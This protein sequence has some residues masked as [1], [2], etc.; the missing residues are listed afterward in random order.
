M[1]SDHYPSAFRGPASS[2]SLSGRNPGP[3][4]EHPEPGDPDKP[5]VSTENE[6]MKDLKVS[7]TN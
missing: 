1:D 2:G 5:G 7:T 6:D 3:A 4:S